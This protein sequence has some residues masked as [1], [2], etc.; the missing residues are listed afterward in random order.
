VAERQIV[1]IG[2]LHFVDAELAEVVTAV[3]GSTA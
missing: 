3:E 2:G 1:A